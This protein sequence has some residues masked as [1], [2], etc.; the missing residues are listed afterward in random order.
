MTIHDTVLKPLLVDTFSDTEIGTRQAQYSPR[1]T[2]IITC[3][4]HV[5][6]KFVKS[7]KYRR[8]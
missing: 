1:C 6:E 2:S 4:E 8:Q 3:K 5:I 7:S